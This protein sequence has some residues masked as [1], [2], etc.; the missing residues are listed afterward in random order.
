[1]A[2]RPAGVALALLFTFYGGSSP[3]QVVRESL[4]NLL[5]SENFDSTGSNWTTL[6]DAENLFIIQDGEYILQRKATNAPYAVLSGFPD[7]KLPF[8]ML[9]SLKLDKTYAENS[10]AG[11]L[12]MMQPQGQGGFLTEINAE[13]KYRIRQI[14][15]G[16]YRYLTGDQKEGGWV[17]NS[18]IKE[19]GEYN[20]I[21]V[22]ASG[23]NY[24]IYFNGRFIQTIVERS[25]A[26]G[27][28]GLIIGPATRAKADYVYIFGPDLPSTNTNAS[29]ETGQSG[30]GDIIALTE[31]I[32]V[33]KTEINTLKEENDGLRKTI[34]AM[35]S[36]EAEQQVTL[37]N[38][39]KQ[40]KNLEAEI[41]RKQASADSLQRINNDLLKYKEMVG[42][43]GS[44]DLVITL[45]RSLKAEKEKN[46]QLEK[47][48]KE[49]REQK[50]APPKQN[51]TKPQ[52]TKEPAPGTI[53]LPVEN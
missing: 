24:D 52:G 35:R 31:S 41:K 22:R 25:Y 44:G 11:I 9:T 36:G 37:K 12:F 42:A 16:A 46:A 15:S 23:G 29:G 47:E 8:R 3:A 34:S 20:A 27:G 50:S 28:A 7:A 6:A 5:I 51:G 26:A 40:V 13:R 38:Y 53:S 1:M 30:E 14:V 49:L 10:F 17:K 32:I 2:V 21:E 45:S 4:D 19:T 48:L 43:N 39:E 18:A 33:L